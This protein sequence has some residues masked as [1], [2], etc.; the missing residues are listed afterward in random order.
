MPTLKVKEYAVRDTAM[1]RLKRHN[2]L[3][4]ALAQRDAD[5]LNKKGAAAVVVPVE[6]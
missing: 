5:K 4:P 6:D 1:R 3:T 2:Y